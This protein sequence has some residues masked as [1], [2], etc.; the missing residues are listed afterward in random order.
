VPIRAERRKHGGKLVKPFDTDLGRPER[1]AGAVALV[2]HPVRQLTT[3]IGSLVRI[4]ARQCLAA[5]EWGDLQRS[6]KQRMPAIGNRRKPKTVCRM[7][8]A[9]R[10]GL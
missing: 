5:S 6:S 8:L 4:D 7:S 10:D 2:E 1:H 9:G 3:K